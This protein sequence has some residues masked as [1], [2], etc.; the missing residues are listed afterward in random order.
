MKASCANTGTKAM[1]PQTL[2]LPLLLVCMAVCSP[3][4][5]ISTAV[6]DA[7]S[8]PIE[9]RREL[10]EQLKA[11]QERNRMLEQALRKQHAKLK[12]VES[13]LA[14]KRA[15]GKITEIAEG[16]HQ[17]LGE[18]VSNPPSVERAL[19]DASV[20]VQAMAPRGPAG[21][22]PF[23]NSDDGALGES[24]GYLQRPWQ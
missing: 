9:V 4:G 16:R 12:N 6:A 23:T 15:V 1:L 13:L 3:V 20:V 21:S 2:A 17:Q 22:H 7:R 5:A 8:V 24:K 14:M 19:E 10:I 18:G 11:S